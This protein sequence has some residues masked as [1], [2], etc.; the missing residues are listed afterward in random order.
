MLGL[1]YDAAWCCTHATVMPVTQLLAFWHNLASYICAFT[2]LQKQPT[3]KCCDQLGALFAAGHHQETGLPGCSAIPSCSRPLCPTE[4]SACGNG[5]T[6]AQVMLSVATLV[7]IIVEA[8]GDSHYIL[9]MEGCALAKLLCSRLHATVVA[10]SS[11][12]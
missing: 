8:L 11:V 6:T 3:T 10:N 4:I 12:C 9:M 7:L 1:S 2:C 5:A